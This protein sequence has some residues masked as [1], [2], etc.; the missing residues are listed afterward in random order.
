MCS[1]HNSTAQQLV[2]PQNAQKYLVQQWF[3][4]KNEALVSADVMIILNLKGLSYTIVDLSKT[5]ICSS[6]IQLFIGVINFHAF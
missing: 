3:I 6:A 4:M 5:S 2:L 1:H